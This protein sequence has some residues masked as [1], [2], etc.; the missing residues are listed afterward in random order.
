MR[1]LG[2]KIKL[3]NF[4]NKT[5]QKYGI[6]GDSFCDLFAGTASVSD[7]FKGSYDIIANDFMYYSYVFSQAKLLNNGTPAFERFAREYNQ[8]IFDWLNAQLYSPN[9]DYFI[10]H[11]Y[12]PIGNRLFF[13]EN[14]AI[15]I[16][17]IRF[18][19]EDLYKKSLVSDNEYYY[20]KASLL[21]CVTRY[22]NTSGT[23]EAFF[24]F[25]ENRALKE[26]SIE[27]IGI[28][29][30]QELKHCIVHNKNSNTLIREVSGDILYLDPP[31]TVTQY[32]SAYNILE[33]IA[34][35]DRP[36]IKGVGG[37][38]D[39]GNC[40]SNYCYAKKAIYEFEDLFRQA[41]FKHVLM[42]YSN[43]G[44]V[45][46]EDIIELAKLF[47][48]NGIVHV[49][50]VEYQEYQNHRSS[51]KRN[52]KKLKEVLIYFE[53]DLSVIKSPLNYAGSK[54][55]M[56]SAIQ[57]Y[58]PKHIDTFVDVM[59]GAFNMGINV[60]STNRVIY[61]DINPYVYQIIEWLLSPNKEQ[62]TQN[63][64]A[65]IQRFGLRKAIEEPYLNL[66]KHYNSEEKNPLNLFVL[67][68]YSFQ[69]YIRFNSKQAF[70]TPIGVAG[71]S[72]DLKKRIQTFIPKTSNVELLNT[73]Y[74]DI[75]YLSFPE[76]T[77]FYFDPP[78]LITKAAYNDGKR[79]MNGWSNEQEKLLYQILSNLNNHN[80]Y[81]I[82]SNVKEHKGK[83][84]IQLIDWANQNNYKIVEMGL[85]GWRYAKSEIIVTNI[86]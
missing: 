15:K 75:D 13:T 36:V 7:Y 61:N 39:K 68:M 41:Q 17:G 40:I 8:N 9:E 5:I 86:K 23:Y 21:D 20:L 33:T 85:S 69:N 80:Y 84:N 16:D 30:C 50:D 56:F 52:G 76:G 19:I 58:F 72:E 60:V 51:N 1:Y 47:A 70:N 28:T 22:S 34:R 57:K 11:N 45:P 38:R 27:P 6:I 43:Q 37:K 3:L 63:V 54:D 42:S 29:T 83:T 79:G 81:F 32:A 48:K 65:C 18:A 4:I 71:Y 25:W 26:F 55:R 66:R 12:S 31:Y 49:E 77:L 53:K 2:S 62:L 59:G 73:D 24:K 35:N 44:V 46:L 10:Y 67:H 74:K 14:N 78:Y 82:L 64:E